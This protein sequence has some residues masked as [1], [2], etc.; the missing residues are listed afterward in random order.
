MNK[1]IAFD[2]LFGGTYSVSLKKGGHQP[3]KINRSA[4]GL[5]EPPHLLKPMHQNV[6]IYFSDTGGGHRSA[7]DAIE[8]SL[9]K[10]LAQSFHMTDVLIIK[11]TVAEKSHVI[12]RFFVE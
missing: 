9:R 5:M 6:C 4:A 11:D 7:A 3:N 8:A 2:L 12:N 1:K 10:L